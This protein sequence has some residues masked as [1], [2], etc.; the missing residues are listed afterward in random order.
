MRH[1]NENIY[2][3]ILKQKEHKGKYT[4]RIKSGRQVILNLNPLC[5]NY[6]WDKFQ[7]KKLK[8]TSGQSRLQEKP[9]LFNGEGG[10]AFFIS[11]M[12]FS[13]SPGNF[14]PS[15]LRCIWRDRQLDI[16][17]KTH[18]FSNIICQCSQINI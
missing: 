3:S 9:K 16:G 18:F 15:E 5:L 2:N 13:N 7:K 6:M 11:S 14:K 17:L 8:L 1:I 4:A 12:P 10:G